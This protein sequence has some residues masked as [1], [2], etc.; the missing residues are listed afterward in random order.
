M[1]AVTTI[2]KEIQ[3]KQ[4]FAIA[5][6][7]S[8]ELKEKK[9]TLTVDNR[10]KTSG[11]IVNNDGSWQI[12]FQFLQPGDR[13][14]KI[15]IGDE[16]ETRT[17]KVIL[18]PPHLRFTSIPTNIKTEEK[19]TLS[20]EADG[21]ENGDQLL[22]KVDDYVVARPLV[23]GGKWQ[24]TVLLHYGGNRLFELESSEQDRVQ[25]QLDVESSDLEVV[26]RL[27]W[28][29]DKPS[30]PV[31]SLADLPNP[32]RITLHH[33]FIPSNPAKT[34]TEEIQRMRK[35]REGEMTNPDQLFSDIGYHFVIM[36]SGRIYEGRP[37]GKRGAHDVINDGF[38]IAFDG[39]YTTKTITD[40]QFKSAVALC[41][42]LCQRMGI[43][44]PVTPVPTPTAFSGNPIK[45]LPRIIGHRDRWPTDCPGVKEGKT[46][47]LEDIRQAVKQA[48][49]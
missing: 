42:K 33:F 14:L 6:T 43:K 21:F 17:I 39:D 28:L 37:D 3:A 9:I 41:T 24:A 8:P 4:T 48:L 31:K 30:P 20:G 10:F 26:P 18:A 32:K 25:I 7:A 12:E 16:S 44:D 40:E 46:V 29:G 2:P 45:N 49:S 34:Q 38:G 1:I 15:S 27:V 5:G 22:L 19:F 11:N 35:V 36:A 13:I 47:R 23:N